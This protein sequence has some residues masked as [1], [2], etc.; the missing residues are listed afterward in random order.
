MHRG[1]QVFKFYFNALQEVILQNDHFCE[2]LALHEFLY[3][4]VFG[5]LVF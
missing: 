1:K 2:I 4:I 5:G 3:L